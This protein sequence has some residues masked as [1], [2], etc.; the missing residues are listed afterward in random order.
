VS[1]RRGEATA[2]APEV[3][4]AAA[5]VKLSGVTCPVTALRRVEDVYA[6]RGAVPLFRRA[7]LP[8]GPDLLVVIVHGFGEHSGRYEGVGRWLARRGVAVHAFDLRGHGRSPG[9]RGHADRFER[10]LDD[11]EDF[12]AFTGELHPALP[13]VVLG[14]GGGALVAVTFAADRLPSIDGLV[15]SAPALVPGATLPWTR[16]RGVRLLRRIWPTWT[17]EA[18]RDVAALSRDPE[19]VRA[20]GADARVHRR[21]SVAFAAGALEAQEAAL[22]RAPRIEAPVLLMQGEADALCPVEASRAFYARLPHDRVPGSAL[23]TYPGLRHEVLNE[24]ER[25][26]VLGDLLAWLDALPGSGRR[27]AA[28]G[29]TRSTEGGA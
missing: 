23:R 8:D 20:Y 22:A 13:R 2:I 4:L 5:A 27:A 10:L 15:L 1:G 24:P 7:W 26:Q 28:G 29:A 3:R 18:P 11:L 6:T 12:L 17:V 19:T 9:R 14:Q 25:E 21:T 16:L